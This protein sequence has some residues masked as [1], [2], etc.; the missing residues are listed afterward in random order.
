MTLLLFG[1]PFIFSDGLLIALFMI[2]TLTNYLS[3]QAKL[4]CD[5]GFGFIL[6]GL[7]AAFTSFIMGLFAV[8]CLYYYNP[9]IVPCIYILWCV[10]EMFASPIAYETI[11]EALN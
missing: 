2:T 1:H 6:I 10:W 5:E 9:M 11:W 3:W 7:L 8:V 4:L